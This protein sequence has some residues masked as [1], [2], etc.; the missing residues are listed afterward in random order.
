MKC[1]ILMCNEMILMIIINENDNNDI[2]NN[3]INIII[4]DNV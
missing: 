2:I 4:N 3:D 1:V